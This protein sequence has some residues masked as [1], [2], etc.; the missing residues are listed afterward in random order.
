M[1]LISLA[2]MATYNQVADFNEDAAVSAL[3][4]CNLDDEKR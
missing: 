1:H 2:A 3:Y 4:F